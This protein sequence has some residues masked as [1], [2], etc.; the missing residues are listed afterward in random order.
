MWKLKYGRLNKEVL[1]LKE[2]YEDYKH[3]TIEKNDA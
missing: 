2:R 1:E 3:A